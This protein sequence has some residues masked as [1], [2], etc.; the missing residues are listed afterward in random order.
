MIAWKSLNELLGEYAPG[1]VHRMRAQDVPV[2]VSLSPAGLL[3]Q[4]R[5]LAAW[6][7][8]TFTIVSASPTAEELRRAYTEGLLVRL[9]V[10]THRRARD[11]AES[12]GPQ[13]AECRQ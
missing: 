5:R 7:D 1:Q 10:E 2:L 3:P 11:A 9:L 13:G 12:S 4:G 6:P 8:G